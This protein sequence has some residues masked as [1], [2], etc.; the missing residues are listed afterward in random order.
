MMTKTLAKLKKEGW[1]HSKPSGKGGQYVCRV[2]G[3]SSRNFILYGRN[4]NELAGNIEKY[5]L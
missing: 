5:V 2:W 1:E 4:L 3:K